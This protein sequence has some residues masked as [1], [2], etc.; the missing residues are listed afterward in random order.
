MD[1]ALGLEIAGW[2]GVVA[3]LCAYAL[4]SRGSLSGT[5]SR[6]HASNVVGAALVAASATALGNWAV[7][8]GQL[9]WLGLGAAALTRTARVRPRARPVQPA[10]VTRRGRAQEQGQL[11]PLIQTGAPQVCA[12]APH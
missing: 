9:V 7:V 11:A 4:V 3:Q 12:A 6:Y 10:D 5:S 2:I 1:V 8:V